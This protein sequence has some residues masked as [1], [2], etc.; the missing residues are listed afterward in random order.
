[1]KGLELASFQIISSV[2]T[3]KSLIM[4][5]LCL[6]NEKKYDEAE[7]KITEANKQL[8]EGHH[9]HVDL[10]QKEANGEEVPFSLLFMHAEDQLMTA[11]TLR[12]LAKEMIK[13]YKLI[14]L[15]GENL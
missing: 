10:I 3:A 4:E 13:M 7:T 8:L 2:G 14:H 12:D 1:M 6:A 9:G 15:K 11:M 5:A